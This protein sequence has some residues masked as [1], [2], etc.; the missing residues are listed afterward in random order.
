[1]MIIMMTT[2]TRQIIVSFNDFSYYKKE[3]E[4]RFLNDIMWAY[5]IACLGVYLAAIGKS[6]GAFFLDFFGLLDRLFVL[7]KGQIGAFL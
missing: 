2:T 7:H 1:M 6:L 5:S 3:L 4:L